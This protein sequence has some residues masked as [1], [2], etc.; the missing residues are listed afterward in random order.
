MAISVCHIFY[1]IS[2]DNYHFNLTLRLHVLP[3]LLW[4]TKNIIHHFGTGRSDEI[5]R[6]GVGLQGT[7]LRQELLLA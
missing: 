2:R 3:R 7:S 5:Y 6:V 1:L 4:T